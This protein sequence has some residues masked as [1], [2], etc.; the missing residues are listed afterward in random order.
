MMACTVLLLAPLS[1]LLLPQHAGTRLVGV[2]NT[3]SSGRHAVAVMKEKGEAAEEQALSLIELGSI[4]E[5]SAM[6]TPGKPTMLGVVQGAQAKSKGG[7]KYV[8][9][10]AN[11]KQHHCATR[12]IHIALKP[13]AAKKKDDSPAAVLAEYLAVAEKEATQLGVDPEL[14]EIAW[15]EAADLDKSELSAANILGVVDESLTKGPLAQYRAF[16]LLTSDVGKIFFKSLSHGR[17]K[18]KAAKSVRGTKDM[19]CRAPQAAKQVDFCFV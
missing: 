19:W 6:D 7:A 5:F 9:V 13:K 3:A 1:A 16:R 12:D 11:N 10:D 17:Y 14:L 8:L 2:G 18:A 4:C 15:E